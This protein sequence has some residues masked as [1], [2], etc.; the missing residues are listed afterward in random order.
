M[1]L[2]PTTR[3]GR[4]W[5]RTVAIAVCLT[6]VLGSLGAGPATAQVEE[7]PTEHLPERVLDVADH[8]PDTPYTSGY[9]WTG[10]TFSVTHPVLVSALYGG[11][12]TSWGADWHIG[13]Y[14]VPSMTMS[15]MSA[16]ERLASAELPANEE[17]TRVDVDDT[18]L[19]PG[20]PYLVAQGQQ[21]R[22]GGFHH[23]VLVI[24]TDELVEEE[25]HILAW[26]PPDGKAFEWGCT[27]GPD[28]PVDQ[29][30]REGTSTHS[31][32]LGVGD[33]FVGR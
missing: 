1:T 8:S 31:P 6:L 15:G 19:I 11:Y 32:H 12:K 7:E 22:F 2:E 24:D 9:C 17:F 18:L 29:E 13:L 16:I 14:L 20:Q 21:D 10:Y 25:T 33:V 3:T 5:T 23:K 28:T 27:G 26:G 30:A 4:R